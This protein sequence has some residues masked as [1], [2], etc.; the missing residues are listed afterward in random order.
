MNGYAEKKETRAGWRGLPLPFV[1]RRFHSILGVWLV[2]Y[3]CEHLWV[4]AGAALYFEDHGAAFIKAVNQIHAIP[5]LKGVEVILLG[6][7]FLI[8]GIWGIL[9]A[10]SG[11]LNAHKTDGSKPSLPMYGRNKAY[12]W[13][14]IT[15]WLLVVGI[16]A[17]V[18]HMR[19]VEYP[20]KISRGSDHFYSVR[21]TDDRG[22]DK[23]A[24]TLGAK[25]ES[26]GDRKIALAPTPGAAFFLIVR[27]AF[28]NPL[29]VILYSLLVIGAAYHAFNGLWTFMISWGIIVTP[30]VQKV[31]L[32]ITTLLMA[33]VIFLGL[34][35]AW[36]TYWVTQF[37]R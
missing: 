21:V 12:S 7:P 18:V 25:L 31:A 37:Q 1:L 15:A 14:R 5:Y 24:N 10:W 17:H 16:I 23:T 6:L 28:K 27:E 36:G 26:L 32:M 11:K 30:T 8:H 33:V 3:L 19:W 2:V 35:A 34:M 13:Q 22:L 29:I 9:Y 20:Q 4:N